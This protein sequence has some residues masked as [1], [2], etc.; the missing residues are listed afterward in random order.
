ME[1]RQLLAGDFCLPI[2][3]SSLTTALFAPPSIVA[4]DRL[5]LGDV[6]P[7]IDRD[8][9]VVSPNGKSDQSFFVRDDMI[10]VDGGSSF[11]EWDDLGLRSTQQY[12]GSITVYR[13]PTEP[14]IGPSFTPALADLLSSTELTVLPVFAVAD[15]DGKR[16]LDATEKHSAQPSGVSV[17][18]DEIHVRWN[19]AD[20]V[21]AGAE[22][23]ELE[24]VESVRRLPGTDDQFIVTLA[25]KDPFKTIDVAGE[26]NEKEGVRW[27][28]PN[29]YH[30]IEKFG[31][32][33]DPL[34]GNQ[35]HS[36]NTGQFGGLVD[37]DV[38][39]PEA[40]DINPGGS[41]DIIV[42]VIDDGVSNDHEDL[43]V[44]V[45]PGEIAGD[46]IDNDG[47]GWIDDINGW[48]FVNDNNNSSYTADGDNHG[49]AVAGLA[50]ADGDNGIGVAGGAYN[51]P[52]ISARIFEGSSVAST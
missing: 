47:N 10:A 2:E 45:N 42:G 13:L 20:F 39:L 27:S 30:Q 50:A 12:G 5:Q 22:L 51:S 49:T 7:W 26:L 19:H 18:T 14:A 25:E 8:D 9:P 40:W 17:A 15:E 28:V 1:S 52:V 44:W 43:T 37:H 23:T 32:P 48:N 16:S 11:P 36:D 34:F 41:A 6:I 38:N 29:W 33:N 3:S 21:A 46:G 35:W 24:G 4:E 31:I